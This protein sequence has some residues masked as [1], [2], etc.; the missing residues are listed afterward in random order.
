MATQTPVTLYSHQ[1]PHYERLTEILKRFFFA[2]D[3]STPG[4]GK[5][6]VTAKLSQDYQLP[7]LVICPASGKVTWR[8][9]VQN[10]GLMHW[11]PPLREGGK[12]GTDFIVSYDTLR[13]KKNAGLSHSLLTRVDNDKDI[14]YFVT[15]TFAHIVNQGALIIFDE[16]Q[17]VKNKKS[18]TWLAVKTMME[19]IY[20]VKPARTRVMFLSGTIMDKEEQVSNF[21]RLVGF[22]KA[23][24]MYNTNRDGDQ[25]T[26]G[27]GIGEVQ[28]WAKVI[29]PDGYASFNARSP[30]NGRITKDKVKTYVFEIFRDVIRPKILSVM[31]KESNSDKKN[32]YYTMSPVDEQRYIQAVSELGSAARYNPETGAVTQNETNMGAIT[33]ALVNIQKSKV[34]LFIRLARQVLMSRPKNA[35]GEP[36]YPKVLIFADYHEVIDE[37]ANGLAEFHPLKLTGQVKQVDRDMI[38]DMFNRFDNQ[39]RLIIANK[40]VGGVS[41]NLHDLEGHFNRY[42]F[43]NPGYQINELQQAVERVDRIG[44]KSRS[45]VRFVYGI[46]GTQETGIM[47][48]LAKKG[49]VMSGILAD[50]R[51]IFPGGYDL[52]FEQDPR[53]LYGPGFIDA[54]PNPS[55]AAIFIAGI[56]IKARKRTLEEEMAAVRLEDRPVEE[57][58]GEEV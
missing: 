21:L 57:D 42:V 36:I 48:S 12:M 49:A 4:A 52:N 10:Y 5:T 9:V 14:S 58:E 43:L 47:N 26:K 17:K 6:F 15:E 28:D 1:I 32:G 30:F 45:T 44:S 50:Q 31:P 7:I 22:L 53:V 46:A 16:C 3:G 8:R 39:S 24:K 41:I 38:V 27:F 11:D 29:N 54:I 18:F 19:Y 40:T 56:Q 51:I 25:L 20:L 33:T 55:G 13:G 23:T 2:I 34:N 37:I 35:L